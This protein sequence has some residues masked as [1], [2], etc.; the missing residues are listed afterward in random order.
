[1]GGS[2][3]LVRGPARH[4]RLPLHAGIRSTGAGHPRRDVP[5]VRLGSA[6]GAGAGPRERRDRAPGRPARPRDERDDGTSHRG[7][8]CRGRARG[9]TPESCRAAARSSCATIGPARPSALSRRPDRS[10][11]TACIAPAR[12]STATGGPTGVRL[13]AHDAR[14]LRR[15][16]RA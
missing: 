2:Q 10:T 1:M 5:R 4:R 13:P 6:V 8:G 14:G 9:G 11:T 7:A 3:S 12:L 15:A 16:T